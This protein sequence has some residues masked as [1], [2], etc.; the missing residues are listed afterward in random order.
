MRFPMTIKNDDLVVAT[1]GRSFWILD[2]IE[3]LRQLSADIAK[4]DVHFYTPEPAWRAR[5]GRGFGRGG[6][7]VGMNPPSGAIFDYYLKEDAKGPVTLDILDGQGNAVRHF[8]SVEQRRRRRGE[9]AETP[10]EFEEFFGPAQQRLPAKAG[11]NRFTWD[12]RYEAPATVPGFALWGGRPTG[13]LAVPG[14]YKAKLNV[15][16]KDFTVPF[17]VKLDPRVPTSVADLQKQFDLAMKIAKRVNEAHEAVNQMQ[18]LRAQLTDLH[19]RFEKDPNAKVVLTSADELVKK[20]TPIE[21]EIVQ[22]KSKA[23]EDPLNYPIRLN[24]KLVD[25]QGTVESADTAPTDQSY[26]VFDMLSGQLDD[27]LAKWKDV[28]SKDVASINDLIR[29]GNMPVIYISAGN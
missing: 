22:T 26:Q 13:P 18:E 29:K 7:A 23:S 1:H 14:N 20:L 6:G 21:E 25:L 12:L 16:G 15:N 5:G 3:P 11:M 28:S 9:G 24:N 10:S 4:S 19:D 17:E 8:S 2:D 27:A